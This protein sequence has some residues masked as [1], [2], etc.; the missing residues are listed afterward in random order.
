VAGS[1]EWEISAILTR[2]FFLSAGYMGPT[3]SWSFC[4][5]VLA[6]LGK[7]INPADAV[8]WHRPDQGAFHLR[9]SPLGAHEQP[10]VSNLPPLDYALLLV[11]TAKFYLGDLFALIEEPIF[12]QRVHEFYED[13]PGKARLARTWYAQFLLV[14][15]FGKACPMSSSAQAP[16]GS[17]FALRAM[18]MMPDI[19]GLYPDPVL[20][21]ST[22]AL[23]AL[24]FQ[25]V[26]MRISAYYHVSCSAFLREP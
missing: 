1:G 25:S 11:N 20:S 26:D 6:L 12:T 23:A 3:S 17:Q 7:F 10:D 21:V 19:S 18:S 24:Y 4:R 8:P 5:R 9:W 16:P 2:S 14:L 13:P 22:M 15:A